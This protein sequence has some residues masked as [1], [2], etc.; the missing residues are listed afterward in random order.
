[1][2]IVDRS[3]EDVDAPLTVT[4]PSLLRLIPDGAESK[5]LLLSDGTRIVGTRIGLRRALQPD[6]VPGT[7]HRAC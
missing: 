4:R 2:S 5:D 7:L 1:V 3:A 6:K